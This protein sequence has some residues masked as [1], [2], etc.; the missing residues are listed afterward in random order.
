MDW[1]REPPREL[2]RTHK[3]PI[4]I[5][6]NVLKKRGE[7]KIETIASRSDEIPEL[8]PNRRQNYTTHLQ[9]E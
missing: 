9:L 2:I 5:I 8:Y 6:N 1:P 4:L 3:A 7:S